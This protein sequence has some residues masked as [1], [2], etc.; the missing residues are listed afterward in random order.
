LEAAKKAAETILEE[1]PDLSS[2]NNL[3][4]KTYL[5]L[6]KGKTVWSKIS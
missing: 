3:P 1:D 5:Q 6:Q 2:E 4:L